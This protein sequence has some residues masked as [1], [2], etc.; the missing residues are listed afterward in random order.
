[1]LLAS[2]PAAR[3]RVSES[4]PY[5]ARGCPHARG[6]VRPL[7]GGPPR[8]P[9]LPRA[10]QR[11]STPAPPPTGDTPHLGSGEGGSVS[12]SRKHLATG[13][14]ASKH[15]SDGGKDGDKESK[16]RVSRL[17]PR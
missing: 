1:M 4:L 5:T 14:E 8:A 10:P 9:L 7:Y 3:A 6:D 2:M 17:R 12:A 15:G 11:A 16:P 13:V